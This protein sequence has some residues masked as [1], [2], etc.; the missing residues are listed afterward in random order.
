MMLYPILFDTNN[1]T[2]LKHQ[3]DFKA[4]EYLKM[5]A[6]VDPNQLFVKLD[7]LKFSLDG[8]ESVSELLPQDYKRYDGN[9]V[10]S[11]VTFCLAK[12]IDQRNNLEEAVQF[13]SENGLSF[14]GILS[15]YRDQTDQKRDLVLLGNESAI[16]GFFDLNHPNV[17]LINVTFKCEFSHALFKTS[18]VNLTRKY[19]QP[20]LIN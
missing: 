1:L 11:S 15:I 6:E 18:D 17:S 2:L 14:Y 13:M 7:E 4:V 9:W 19:C 12:W 16:K 20:V 8:T 5:F 10:M 3:I